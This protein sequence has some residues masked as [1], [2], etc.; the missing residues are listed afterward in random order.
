MNEMRSGFPFRLLVV[1]PLVLILGFGALGA[2][3][4][5]PAVATFFE[6][7][8]FVVYGV[9]LLAVLLPLYAVP[10][11]VAAMTRVPGLRSTK[12]FLAIACSVLC[13]LVAL[14]LFLA[15]SVS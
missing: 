13:A 2:L 5:L 10:A 7:F 1:L 3:A 6:A 4:E 11:G 14:V 8:A 12:H 9:L 15:R